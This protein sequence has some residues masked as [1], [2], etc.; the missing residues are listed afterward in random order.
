MGRRVGGRAFLTVGVALA[1]LVSAASAGAVSLDEEVPAVTASAELSPSKLPRAHSAPA[2]LTL[3]FTS[4]MPESTEIPRLAQ[5][6][7]DLSHNVTLQSNDLPSCTEARLLAS[8]SSYR[9][10]CPGSLVGTGSVSSEVALYRNE[11]PVDVSGSLR[12]Y[13]SE[14]GG[15]RLILAQVKSAHP[16]LTYV[17]PFTLRRTAPPF[18]VSLLLPKRGM[19]SMRGL[20]QRGHPECFGTP[21]TL[22]GVYS[23][24]SDFEM[25][26]HRLFSRKGKA[27]SFIRARCGASGGQ[28]SIRFPLA[29]FQLEYATGDILRGE[30]DQRCRVSDR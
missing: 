11:E 22:E 1:L 8:Y 10:S 16:P 26:L 17:I 25:T 28:T 21:Y 29:R 12:A 19:T 6:E 13:Y 15:R 30:T 18:G 24:I 23:H 7:I 20:C 3:G 5:I 9:A 27:G 2:S 14:E 4:E